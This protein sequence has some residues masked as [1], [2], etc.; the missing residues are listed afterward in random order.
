MI[1]Y[2]IIGFYILHIIGGLVGVGNL[3][4]IPCKRTICCRDFNEY[5]STHFIDHTSVF[6]YTIVEKLI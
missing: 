5:F 1:V 4:L 2:L 3:A 6:I